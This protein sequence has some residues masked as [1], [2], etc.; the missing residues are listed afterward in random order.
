MSKTEQNTLK[1]HTK[2]SKYNRSISK[3]QQNTKHSYTTTPET[4]LHN[5]TQTKQKTTQN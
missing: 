1:K 5:I 2:S 3:I 4:N